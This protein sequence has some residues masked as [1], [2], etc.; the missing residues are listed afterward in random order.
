MGSFLLEFGGGCYGLHTRLD[1]SVYYRVRRGSRCT[2]EARITQ[3]EI[4]RTEPAFGGQTFGNTGAYDHIYAR[5]RGEVDP[6]DPKNAIVQD[7]NLAPRNT[8]GLVEYSTDVELLKP[9]D[10]IRGNRILLFEVNNR[11][12]KLAPVVFD[13]GISGSI[14][15]RNALSTSGDGYLMRE[16]Y[17]LVWWGWEMDVRAGWNRILMPPIVA[18]NLDGSTITGIVRSEMITPRVTKTLPIVT[19]Q[20]LQIFP[21]ESFDSYPTV[22][23]D[24]RTPLPDGFLPV[25][26]KRSHEQS[27]RTV[28]PNDQWSFANCGDG[29]PPVPDDKHL[30]YPTGFQPGLHTD[31]STAPVIQWCWASVLLLHVISV[32]S[33]AALYRMMLAGL[34]P[35]YRPEQLAIIEGSSQSG[36]MIRSFLALGFNQD[37]SGRRVFDG[38]YPHIGGGLMPLNIRFGQPLR[39]WGEQTDHT[40]PAYDFPFSYTPN[41]IR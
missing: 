15:D 34:T 26:T 28:I 19:S 4:L 18:H 8:Q 22:S 12:N 36:R 40:Y 24:N 6:A 41:S 27:P 9:A 16:G 11:G 30:C 7:L 21:F 3:F 32:H 14:A 1:R 25:L 33:C 10:Q 2:G 23:I 37:E 17:T 20:Q 39:A 13:V 38:A 31:L 5:V 29:Q 35:W